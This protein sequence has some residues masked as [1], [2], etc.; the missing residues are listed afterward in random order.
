MPK[1]SVLI[2]IYNV[3][4][5]IEASLDSLR[6]QTLGDFEAICVNDGSTDGS[7]AILQRYLDEDARFRVIDKEN[8][9]YGASMNRA[10][11]EATGEYVAILEPDDLYEPGALELL[12]GAADAAGAQVA[13]ADFWLYWSTPQERRERFGFTEGLPQGEAVRPQDHLRAFYRK[14]SIWSAAYR[15][16]FLD[17][18]GIRFTE[19]PG[20]SF[21]DAAFNFKVWAMAE[22]VVF[23]PDAV[24]SYRQD[25]EQSSV[26]SPAKVFCVCDEYDEMERFLAERP[27]RRAA[28]EGVKE[29]MKFDTYLWNYDRLAPELRERFFE[30][31]SAEFRDDMARGDVDL[32]LFEP[33]AEADLRA[34]LESPELFVRCRADAGTRGKLGAFRHY[35]RMGGLPL[36]M[37]VLRAKREARR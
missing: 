19:T 20:A 31:A 6:A 16:D 18:N 22:R 11:A 4:R 13:K 23:L 34:M 24:L 8:S 37:K 9:G 1:V 36:V 17:A 5:Y 3:E 30:R 12:V 26:N 35:W 27:E 2:P 10:L 29:R 14:P 33:W 25:N 15:R 28:L 32:A 21:Q 7:R